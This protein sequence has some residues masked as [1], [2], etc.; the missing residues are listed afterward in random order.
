MLLSLFISGLSWPQISHNSSMLMIILFQIR[1]WRRRVLRS[2][3]LER[4]SPWTRKR[5]GKT[6]QCGGSVNLLDS[7]TN[8]YFGIRIRPLVFTE[9]CQQKL[10]RVWRACFVLSLLS[11]LFIKCLFKVLNL[12]ITRHFIMV[13][14]CRIRIRAEMGARSWEPLRSRAPVKIF[15]FSRF[16]VNAP[17]FHISHFVPVSHS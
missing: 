8:S 5:L 10:T 12:N 13:R 16:K 9:N 6:N 14:Q 11:Y 1:E 7:D 2:R 15:F 4:R 3:L 17:V